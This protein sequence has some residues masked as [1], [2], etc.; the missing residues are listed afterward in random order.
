MSRSLE[1]ILIEALH[2]LNAVTVSQL[3]CYIFLNCK[4]VSNHL[5]DVHEYNFAVFNNH[6]TIEDICKKNK[7]AK[8][9]LKWELQFHDRLSLLS[10]TDS[11]EVLVN[12]QHAWFLFVLWQLFGNS[13]STNLGNLNL[14]AEVVLA[15]RK[16]SNRLSS[17]KGRLLPLMNAKSFIYSDRTFAFQEQN[18]QL[19]RTILYNVTCMASC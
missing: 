9:G 18:V 10:P 12:S 2:K 7:Q 16:P 19:K 6:D 1:Q 13:Y 15:L 5:L 4:D 3:P 8:K 11:M 14:Q 17:W